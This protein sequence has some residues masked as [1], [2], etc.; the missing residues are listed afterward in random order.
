MDLLL[1]FVQIFEPL[2]SSL[3]LW[4]KEV[5]SSSRVPA[6]WRDDDDKDF[7]QGQRM[8]VTHVNLSGSCM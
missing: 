3:Y 6:F 8:I 4:V 2:E 5:N 1:R 7:D